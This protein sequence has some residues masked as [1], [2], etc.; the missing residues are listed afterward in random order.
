MSRHEILMYAQVLARQFDLYVS[1]EAL[2]QLPDNIINR[3]CRMPF[4]EFFQLIETLDPCAE[5]P[6]QVFLYK[7]RPPDPVDR[8]PGACTRMNT[9]VMWPASTAG[10]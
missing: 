8:V 7:K 9:G 1:L 6:A 10:L 2:E 3:I 5:E 4:N